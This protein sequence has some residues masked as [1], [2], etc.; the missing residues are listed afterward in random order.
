LT[1]CHSLSTLRGEARGAAGVTKYYDIAPLTTAFNAARNRRLIVYAAWRTHLRLARGSVSGPGRLIVGARWDDGA[2][3]P[4]QFVVRRGASCHVGGRFRI[5][6]GCV[7]WVESG[8]K[9]SLGSGYANN[10]LNLA[11]AEEIVIGDDVAIADHVTIRD[12][13]DHH[14]SGGRP[15]TLPVRIGNHVWIG[16]RSIILKGAVLDDGAVVAAGSVVTG[17][18]APNT[19]VAGI[20]A[21]PIRQVCWRDR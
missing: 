18:V 8:A 7:V 6:T 20:P 15:M 10:S 14:I 17:H 3:V 11:C 4:S 19:L 5:H 16:T 1:G 9:L 12:S 21:R 2:F 13:D